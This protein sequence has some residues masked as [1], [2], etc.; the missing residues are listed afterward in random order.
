[1][2]KN[3]TE[4]LVLSYRDDA[5]KVFRK[6]YRT[7]ITSYGARKLNYSFETISRG[8]QILNYAAKKMFSVD[9]DEYEL[10]H[11]GAHF[12]C[13]TASAR[14]G[15]RGGV[16]QKLLFSE[17]AFYPDKKELR[18]AEIIEGTLRQVDPSAGMVFVEST[19]N[20]ENNY[21]HKMWKE[22]EAGQS[23]FKPRFLAGRS[24]I[25]LRSSSSSRA[26]SQISG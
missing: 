15:G 9:S 7:F 14:T 4:T 3:P 26:S 22:A 20:G 21:Y 12:Y 5:T 23:R 16:V 6:R 19:A 13:G 24:F 17:A 10:A 2:S 25:R 8:P 1:M 18:A 11:N